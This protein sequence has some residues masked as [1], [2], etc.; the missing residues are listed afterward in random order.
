MFFDSPPPAILIWI[1]FFIAACLTMFALYKL[2]QVMIRE[3]KSK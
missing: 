1:F 2:I 3:S